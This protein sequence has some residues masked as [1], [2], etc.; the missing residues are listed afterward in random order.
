MKIKD[1]KVGMKAKHITSPSG[2]Y[3][4]TI[5]KIEKDIFY[6]EW[7]N[8]VINYWDKDSL[9]MFDWNYT[10]TIYQYNIDF[11]DMLDN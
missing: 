10:K 1:L 8:N 9:Y 4:A 2:P 7:D 11:Q 5:V 6:L 3:Y